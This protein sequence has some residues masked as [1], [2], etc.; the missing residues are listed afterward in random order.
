VIQRPDVRSVS[1]EGTIYGS[2]D[3]T[4]RVGPPRG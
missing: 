1:D 3:Q 4:E 2:V